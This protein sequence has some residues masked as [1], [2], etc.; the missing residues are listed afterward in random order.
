MS[1]ENEKKILEQKLDYIEDINRYTVDMLEQALS[2]FDFNLRDQVKNKHYSRYDLLQDAEN[3]VRKILPLQD[4]AFFLVNEQEYD[5]ELA[6]KSEKTD[7]EFVN[8]EIEQLIENWAFSWALRKKRPLIFACS[9]PRVQVILHVMSTS[10][11]IRGMFFATIAKEETKSLPEVSLLLLSTTL[12]VCSNFLESIELYEIVNKHNI[13]LEKKVQERTKQ[14]EYQAYYDSLTE[15]PNRHMLFEKLEELISSSEQNPFAFILIDLNGFKEVNDALGHHAG[16]IV[17][18]EIGKILRQAVRGNDIMGRLGGDEFSAI[19]PSVENKGS[20]MQVAERFLQKLDQF[21]LLDGRQFHIDASIGIALYPQHASDASDLMRKADIAMY[22]CKREKRGA[23]VYS[24][25]KD[26]HST[27]DVTIKGDLKKALDE[28]HIFPLFQP[29]YSLIQNRITG[30]EALARWT[31]PQ[32]GSISPGKFIP[33]AEK[34]GL[35]KKLTQDL[36]ELSVAQA[37]SWLERGIELKIGIN[38]SALDLQDENLPDRI[39]N[40]IQAYNLPFQKIEL[41][42]TESHIMTNP[43]VAI[44]NIRRLHKLGLTISLD[45]FGTGYSSL[46]YLHMFPVDNIKIDLSFVKT[47]LD[48]EHNRTIVQ[49][50][51]HLGKSLQKITVAEGVETKEIALGLKDMGCDS[52]QGYYVGKPMSNDEVESLLAS[53]IIFDDQQPYIHWAGKELDLPDAE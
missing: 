45:D 16:D 32:Y 44:S 12:L 21:F 4:V 47:M 19:L 22:K 15:L 49:S 41:E 39:S 14:L 20:A 36:L 13:L 2:L 38:L 35:I 9:D 11:R 52:L 1:T 31:H 50:I 23:T 18:T 26:D 53:T 34:S 17:L 42:I 30:V 3:R 5:F 51:I 48:N 29:R 7:Q 27:F 10:S 37:K 8:S 24:V 46:S 28:K 6:Y 33:L 25:E 43:D 40:I